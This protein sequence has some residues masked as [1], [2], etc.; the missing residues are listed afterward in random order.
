V[1][2]QRRK[3]SL[4]VA[5]AAGSAAAACNEKVWLVWRWVANGLIG[6]K[7]CYLLFQIGN[8]LI[9]SNK[10]FTLDKNTAEGES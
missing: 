6:F 7:L 1:P 8:P 2:Q 4:I 5:A 9:K 10:A 3:T